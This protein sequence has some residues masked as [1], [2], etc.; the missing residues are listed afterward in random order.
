MHYLAVR[1][2][3]RGQ[4]WGARILADALPEGEVA[5]RAHGHDGYLGALLEVES[6]DGPPP[7]ADREQRVRRHRFYRRLGALD[8]GAV[9]PRPPFTPPDMPDFDLLLVP[10][11]AF[12]GNIDDAL[13]RRLIYSLAV[14]AY[15]T[16]PDE[17]WLVDALRRYEAPGRP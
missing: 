6:V 14:E 1:S 11:P 13:R 5:A 12:D 17:P 15:N 9:Y 2:D 10:G 3:L 7:D 8:V 16:P 4:G